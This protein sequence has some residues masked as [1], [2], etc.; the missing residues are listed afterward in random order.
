[1]LNIGEQRGTQARGSSLGL[2]IVRDLMQLYGGSIRIDRSDL[3][4]LKVILE[5]PVFS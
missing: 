1:M 4:G 2:A 3:G 5:V